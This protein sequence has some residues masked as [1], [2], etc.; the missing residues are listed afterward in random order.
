M[1][2]PAAASVGREAARGQPE[3]GPEAPDRAE[4]GQAGMDP[5]EVVAARRDRPGTPGAD[6]AFHVMV[7][8]TN[9]WENEHGGGFGCT[10]RN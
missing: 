5:A 6:T 10:G 7:D 4:T 9:L 3:P 1:A 2:D 8:P